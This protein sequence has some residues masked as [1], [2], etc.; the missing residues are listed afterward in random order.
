MRN[1]TFCSA[2]NTNIKTLPNCLGAFKNFQEIV[3]DWNCWNCQRFKDFG[4][5]FSKNFTAK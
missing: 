4:M 2:V 1:K 3:K 5:S